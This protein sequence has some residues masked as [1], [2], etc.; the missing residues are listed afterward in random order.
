[1]DCLID[2]TQT[3]EK[4]KSSGPKRNTDYEKLSSQPPSLLSHI[5]HSIIPVMY[6]STPPLPQKNMLLIRPV[7]VHV[8]VFLWTDSSEP[9]F[10]HT[11]PAL[12][13]FGLGTHIPAVLEIHQP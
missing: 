11:K 4:K 7:C 12:I 8:C 6:F 13:G 2:Y 3:E 5:T 9:L 10:L 1:M